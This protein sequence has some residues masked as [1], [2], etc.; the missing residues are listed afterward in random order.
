[1][2]ETVFA[3]GVM[4]FWGAGCKFRGARAPVYYGRGPAVAVGEVGGAVYEGKVLRGLES[5]GLRK[6]PGFGNAV[7]LTWWE[8]GRW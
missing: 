2:Q 6:L 4:Q 5:L 1:M 8:V 7:L 3:V